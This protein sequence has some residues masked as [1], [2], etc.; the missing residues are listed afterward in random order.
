MSEASENEEPK[1][2]NYLPYAVSTL[3][4]QIVPNDLTTFKSRGSSQVEKEFR[5]RMLELKEQYERAVDD[6]H[7]SKL[8]YEADF[9]FEPVMG[10]VYHLYAKAGERFALS[11]VPPGEWRSKDKKW[12]GSFRLDLDRRWQP[13][14]VSGEFD[15]RAFVDETAAQG[16][17]TDDV[18]V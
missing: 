6:F 1:K 5:Q 2:A 12:V 8:V 16:P 17:E 18:E 3:S 7:W 9:G 4:P 10:Q 14:D 15:L 11:M 13:M